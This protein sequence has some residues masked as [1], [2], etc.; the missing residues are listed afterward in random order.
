MAQELMIQTQIS[1]GQPD[2]AMPHRRISHLAKGFIYNITRPQPN[3]IKQWGPVL[4]HGT[5]S[6]SLG[7]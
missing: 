3:L 2:D 6:H 7:R 4:R 1:L 5:A